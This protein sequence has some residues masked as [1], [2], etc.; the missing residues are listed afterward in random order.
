MVGVV[1]AIGFVGM[2]L[3]PCGI[4]L[5]SKLGSSSEDR[6][7]QQAAPP[8][9]FKI[10]AEPA[11]ELPTPQNEL[12]TIPQ[13]VLQRPVPLAAVAAAQRAAPAPIPVPSLRQVAELAARE[14]ILAQA[15][16]A[17]ARAEALQQASRAASRRAA[18]AQKL[19][20]AAESELVR[21]S[22][23]VLQAQAS[24]AKAKEA[25]NP[26]GDSDYLPPDHPSL[27]FPRSRVP[28]RRVA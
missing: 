20:A 1:V 23:A 10:L 22:Q 4:A 11:L 6:A 17:Q 18:A 27:D 8:A 24:K 14:A 2:V 12:S 7:E 16:A 9:S 5:Y 19:A 25:Q 3:A 15:A 21:A 13:A 26:A 28:S